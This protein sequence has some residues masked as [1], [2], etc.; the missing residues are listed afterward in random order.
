MTM[1][2]TDQD[3]ILH[4]G[5]LELI[6]NNLCEENII[7]HFGEESFEY[8][9]YEHSEAEKIWKKQQETNMN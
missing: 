3:K 8:L 9:A 1:I 2:D 5:D 6:A 7:E 4:S